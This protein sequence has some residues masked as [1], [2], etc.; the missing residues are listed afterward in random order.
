[1]THARHLSTA[2]LEEG[3]VVGQHRQAHHALGGRLLRLE[4][5]RHRDD[6]GAD[7]D[8]LF[9]SAVVEVLGGGEEA[10][11]RNAATGDWPAQ[12]LERLCRRSTAD[13]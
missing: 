3:L 11:G 4:V 9:G 2:E 12:P 1:M 13:R 8:E 7:V 5:V 6:A 10:R